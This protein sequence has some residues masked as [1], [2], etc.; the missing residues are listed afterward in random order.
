MSEMTKRVPLH[1]KLPLSTPFSLHIFPAYMC[2]FRCNYCLHSLPEE[3]L[4][5]KGFKRQLMEYDT[6]RR[7][8]DSCAGFTGRL[9]A[10][11]F[12]GHGEPLIH[13]DIARMVAYAKEKQVADRVEIVTNGSLLT[14]KLADDLIAAG[15]DRLRVSV[16]GITGEAYKRTMGKEF[17]FST[18]VEG[19]RYFYKHKKDTEVY[20]KIIDVALT[21]SD[22]EQKFR[23][24]FAPVADEVAIEYE[25]PFVKEVDNG[26]LKENFDRSKQGNSI[27]GAKVCAMPFY[28]LVLT[29]NG[30]VVP[31]CSTDVP[32][33]LGN[34]WE[35]SLPEIWQSARKNGFCRVHLLGNREMHP[36]CSTCSVPQFGMQEGDYLDDY[37]GGMLQKYPVK[38]G[39]E[40][41]S[42][43]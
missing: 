23:D 10:L 9:K 7:A 26:A 31:C 17:D 41:E 34:I 39:E 42:G 19:L 20:C 15:L 2:N 22:D 32:I 6:Y 35:Q 13:S 27:S 5:K 37:A 12:A 25:I 21:E 36:V 24:I 14:R 11:I 18:F 28:M 33:V 29:P 38:W 3:V 8:I 1:E 40:D 30:D 16:Q 4:Q 43:D